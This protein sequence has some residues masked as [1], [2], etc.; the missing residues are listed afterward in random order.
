MVINFIRRSRPKAT[1]KATVPLL[2]HMRSCRP[3][4]QPT[5]GAADQRR[6]SRRPKATGSATISYALMPTKGAASKQMRLSQLLLYSFKKFLIINKASS[7]LI[8]CDRIVIF[9]LIF[10]TCLLIF[11][12]RN[13]SL[14]QI[15]ALTTL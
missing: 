1:D 15:V 10:F 7:W 13:H 14:I 8:I 11:W 5:K 6:R 4:A 9:V 2:F 3:K 12:F